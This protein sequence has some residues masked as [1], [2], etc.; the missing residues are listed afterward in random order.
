MTCK[1]EHIKLILQNTKTKNILTVIK[2]A[3][4]TKPFII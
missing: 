4:L 1:V 3:K 2:H